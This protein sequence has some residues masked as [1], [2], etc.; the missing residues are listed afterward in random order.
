M[1]AH[2]KIIITFFGASLIF[3]FGNFHALWKYDMHVIHRTL[4]LWLSFECETH[5]VFDIV[6]SAISDAAKQK[7][8]FKQLHSLHGW[9][10]STIHP[11][12]HLTQ[13]KYLKK[14]K[15]ILW[16]LLF[17]FGHIVHVYGADKWKIVIICESADDKEW[18][19]F[20]WL[21]SIQACVCVFIDE[22]KTS[23][24]ARPQTTERKKNIIKLRLSSINL[25]CLRR[26]HSFI[27]FFCVLINLI[28]GHKS[29]F[30]SLLSI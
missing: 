15:K 1:W 13:W 14:K 25:F 7:S 21:I 29:K 22:N 11:Q 3:M 10:C 18:N 12:S 24:R 9:G 30:D 27:R 4:F 5:S 8:I 28:R 20:S 26:P 6:E 19:P 2:K 16:N 23:N 17:H